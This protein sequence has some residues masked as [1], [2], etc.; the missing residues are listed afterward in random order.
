MSTTTFASA[1]TQA[2]FRELLGIQVEEFAPLLEGQQVTVIG[3]DRDHRRNGVDREGQCH[4]RRGG[5]HLLRRTS[6]R[7]PMP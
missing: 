7:R 5:R 2:P 3:L 1:A 4:G 6:R